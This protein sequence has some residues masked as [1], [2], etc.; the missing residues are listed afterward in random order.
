MGRIHTAFAGAALAALLVLPALGQTRSQ[1]DLAK[2][3]E[4]ELAAAAKARSDNLNRPTQ[5]WPQEISNKPAAWYRGDEGKRVAANILSWQDKAAGGWPLM[6]P[7]REVNR[8]DP[9]QA[10]P[11]GAGSSM[12]KATVNEIRFMARAY[13]ATG[14]ARYKASALRGIGFIL[15]AQ[16]PS[17]GWPHSY[18]V[19]DDYTRYATYNDDMMPDLMLLLDEASTSGEFAFIGRDM[20]ARTK[21]AF[22]KGVDFILKTQIVSEGR[23]TAWGQQH[24]EKTYEPRAARNFEPVAISG[25]ESAGVLL[26]LMKIKNPSPEVVRAIEAG[27]AWYLRS[28][29]NGLELIQANGDRVVRPNLDAKPLW[30]RFYQ[31]G[32]NRPIFAGRDSVIRYE[33]AQIEK[34]RR[35]GYAWYN[36]SGSAVLREYAKWSAK[37][38][39]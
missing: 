10:G 6:N 1:A 15:T 33:M 8:G 32:T 4:A 11:Y 35:G 28:Q 3:S 25:G 17:G 24:D 16:Y 39:R 36:T 26:L 12:I 38:P 14:D 29:I 37:R 27:V 34:E 13:N 5:W 30:A 19:R 31:I 2:Q 7:T 21:A 18:P 9:A 20:R 22:D 23:L